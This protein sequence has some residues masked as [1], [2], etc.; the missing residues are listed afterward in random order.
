MHRSA[1][2]EGRNSVVF[3][4]TLDNVVFL[5]LRSLASAPRALGNWIGVAGAVRA[6]KGGARIVMYHE[7]PRHHERDFERGLRY[8]LR[9]FEIIPLAAL[10]E[11]L[12]SP[13]PDLLHKAALTFDDGLAN[14]IEVAYPVLRRLRLP[15]T[16]F[17]CP[18]LIDEGRWLW[19]HEARQRLRR[20]SSDVLAEICRESN[21][22]PV[23]EALIE[24]MKV[25]DLPSRSKV[26][27]R[28]R[29]ATPAFSPTT[30]ERHEFG[31][32]NWNDLLRLDPDIVTIGS[33]SLT[34]PILTTLDSSAMRIEIAESRRVLEDK[35]DRPVEF[36][37]YPN[38]KTNPTVRA[39]VAQ[40]Y[41]AAGATVV[42]MET[43]ASDMQCDPHMLPRIS[44]KWSVLK[45]ARAM[46]CAAGCIDV[47]STTR[48]PAR[49]IC[50]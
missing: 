29:E 30:E 45:L 42:A 22:P 9:E 39:C 41:R 33:H 25:L 19:N 36:F 28:I 18:G 27:K 16:F 40:H 6:V 13:G 32:A 34:H 5:G 14:N 50:S 43:G 24:R 49:K 20:L 47:G 37:A 21:V 8:L 46:Y 35:L 7:T 4:Q 17:V 31:L 48:S 1:W 12:R 26:E 44:A 38:G 3:D 11:A 15:A 2:H 23:I 10:V